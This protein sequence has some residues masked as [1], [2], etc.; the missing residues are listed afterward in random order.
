MS[1]ITAALRRSSTRGRTIGAAIDTARARAG[2][3]HLIDQHRSMS[4]AVR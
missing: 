3:S 4:G 2:Q 1:R